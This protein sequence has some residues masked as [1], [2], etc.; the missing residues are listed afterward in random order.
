[1]QITIN[2]KGMQVSDYL[3]EVVQ[4]R[5]QKLDK[6]FQ[7]D[8]RVQVMLSM[9]RGRQV[10]EI[11]VP[12][13]TTI[14]RAEEATGDMY[15]SIDNATKKLE[16]QLLRYRTRMDRQ[17]RE[18]S[19]RF[20]TPAQPDEPDDAGEDA[21]DGEGAWPR[22]VRTKRFSVKPMSVDEAAM[23]MDLL[24]HAFFV[25]CSA[26]SGEVNVLYKRN[27]GQLGLIEPV[28]G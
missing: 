21:E 17:M 13:G 9:F 19:I 2:G 18:Q 22:V 12:I 27:D 25:F 8:V 4:T 6:Y 26:E 28:I 20:F 15:A 23:Q 14:L 5:V 3:S 24:G 16:R 10:A 1:M 7:D 11:T